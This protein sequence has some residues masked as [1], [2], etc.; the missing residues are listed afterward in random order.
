APTRLSRPVDDIQIAKPAL[1][2]FHVRFEQIDGISE[3][4]PAL[5]RLLAELLKELDDVAGRKDG[6]V[7]LFLKPHPLLGVSGDVTPI[8][9]SGRGGQIP[10]R[11]T[12]R[13]TDRD[14][15]MPDLESGI[16]QGIEQSFGDLLRLLRTAA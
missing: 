3:A 15:L 5:L 6:I 4:I 14:H 11:Q 13:V 12:D 8:E 10:L 16:P 1:A 9:E 2:V 7:G